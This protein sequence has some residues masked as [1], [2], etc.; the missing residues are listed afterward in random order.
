MKSITK[1]GVSTTTGKGQEQYV[2]CILGAFWGTEYFQYDYHHTDGEL[3]STL[4]KSLEEC[5]ER[6]DEWLR[7]KNRKRLS[8]GVLKRMKEGKRLTKDEMAYQIGK[9]DPYHGA[10]LYWD[11]LKRDEIR[12]AFC[13]S[14][15]RPASP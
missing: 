9:I 1:N 6:R 5:R 13:G 11:Y 15:S 10:A 2:K 12:D 8:A 3:F 4:A 14:H 7:M